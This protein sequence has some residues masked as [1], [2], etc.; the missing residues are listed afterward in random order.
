MGLDIYVKR[1]KRQ[2]KEYG[3]Y[4]ENNYRSI[5]EDDE[6]NS[7]AELARDYAKCIKRLSVAEGNVDV[8]TYARIH[9]ECIDSIKKHFSYP[10]YDLNSIGFKKELKEWDDPENHNTRG[11]WVEGYTPTTVDC[12]IENF[13]RILNYHYQPSVAYFRK[14]NFLLAYF[15]NEGTLVDEYF[16][17]MDKETCL[18]IIDRCKRVLANHSLASELLPTQSG[19]FLGGT[20]YAEWYYH[21][22]ENVLKQFTK[23]V[24]PVYDELCWEEGEVGDEYINE[25]YNCYFIF[26]W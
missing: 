14:V 23:N 5:I 15:Q 25:K 22:V 17:P 26:S 7:D 8:D 6:K 18:D 12:W 10:E 20:D 2:F 9:R 16:A 3:V 4:T 24:L 13:K 21:D 1:T 19:Y 11:E